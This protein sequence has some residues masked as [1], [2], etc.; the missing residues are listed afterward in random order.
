MQGGLFFQMMDDR[1]D[2]APHGDRGLPVR[3]RKALVRPGLTVDQLV[4][5]IADAIVGG[6]YR[7][8]DKLDEV[9]LAKRFEVSRTP[10]REALGQLS[11]MGLV[12]RRPNRGAIVAIVTQEH[13]SSMFEGMAELEGIC[14]RLSAER[15][16]KDERKVLEREHVASAKLVRNGSWEE[17]EAYNIEFHTR[18]YRGSHNEHLRDLAALTRSRLAPFRRAQFKLPGRLSKSWEEHDAIVKCILRGEGTAAGAAAKAHVVIVSEVSVVFA[19]PEN[20]SGV[21]S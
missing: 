6:D 10:I 13:L 2:Q 7:P 1:A 5:G 20:D 3:S 12:D 18:L 9:M 19:S 8:G 21:A 17:Y 14:A 11:A 15:M 4:R 16:T